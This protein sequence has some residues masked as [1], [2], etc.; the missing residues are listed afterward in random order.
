M[1]G[2]YVPNQHGAWAML[3]L[4]FLLGVA[5]SG[6]QPAHLLFFAC[7]LL[8]YLASFPALLWIRTGRSDR[9]RGPL[10]LYGTLLV[11]LAAALLYAHPFLLW[12]GVVALPLFAVNV[13]FARANRER[14]F[15]ND[16]AAIVLFCAVVFPVASIGS[17]VGVPWR[18]AVDMFAI[19]FAY[20][21]GT[22][23][24]VKTIIRE[25]GNAA[26]YRWSVAYHAVAAIGVAVAIDAWL[27]LPFAVLL[28]R[29]AWLPG[30]GLSVKRTG[31]LEIAFAV[32]VYGAVL[33][34]R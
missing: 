3:V 8:A 15:A 26:F 28:A 33:L 4:P 30:R 29:A 13:R 21:V 20:F 25:K 18:A 19:S 31:M 17:E 34:I 24:Y 7:W 1:K 2:A 32:M 16:L 22:A 23:F 9:S 6:A 27:A 12:F 5:A 11:P 10:L 14:A